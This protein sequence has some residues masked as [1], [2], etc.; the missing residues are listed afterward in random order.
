M[1]KGS[2]QF[3]QKGAIGRG[4]FQNDGVGVDLLGGHGFA[5]NHEARRREASL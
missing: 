2:R 3:R 5:A 4:E 1:R